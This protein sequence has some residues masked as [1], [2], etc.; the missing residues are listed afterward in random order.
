MENKRKIFYTKI[1][2]I[3]SVL[4]AMNIFLTNSYVETSEINP[5]INRL[6]NWVENED[7]DGNFISRIKDRLK[8]A[9]DLVVRVTSP[10][11]QA[12]HRHLWKINKNGGKPQMINNQSGVQNPAWGKK[13][14]I[15][16][17]V[18]TDTN[19]DGIV[20]SRDQINIEIINMENNQSKNIGFGRS[21]AWSPDG[22]NLAYINGSEIWIYNLKEQA[23]MQVDKLK[24]NGNIIFT[25]KKSLANAEKFWFK[26][27]N[28]GKTCPLPTELKKRYLWLGAFSSNGKKIVR[29][30]TSYSDIYI[31]FLE[32]N[33]REIK[34]TDDA[35]TDLEPAWSPD[36]Q[37]VVFV[38]D[39]PVSF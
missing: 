31:I 14:W 38:S 27:L 25:D 19:K 13:N 3:L 9:S 1:L 4:I 39:R 24:L 8:G 11:I 20:D 18:L 12:A 16:Y 7:T 34:L 26:N 6:V 28:N 21:L 36:E 37:W 2:S 33:M 29:S 30:D 5:I 22:E 23:T 10:D 17:E 15:A 32:E 35:Y